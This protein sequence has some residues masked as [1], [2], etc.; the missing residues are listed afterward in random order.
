MDIGL[1]VAFVL[2]VI[3]GLIY[4]RESSGVLRIDHCNPEKDIYRFEIDDLDS[5]NKKKRIIIRIDHN[6]DL[7]QN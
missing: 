7:S 5:L 1:V 2:G 6:A 3:M 4:P